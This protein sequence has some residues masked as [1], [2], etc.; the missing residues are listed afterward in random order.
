MKAFPR[1]AAF[2]AVAMA[3]AVAGC[4]GGGGGQKADVR[5][6]ILL[7]TTGQP[8]NPAATVSIAGAASVLTLTDGTFIVRDAS[9][10]ATE[11]NV[12]AA[13]MTPLRQKLPTLTPNTVNDLG[14]IFLTDATYDAD[15]DGTVVRADTLAPLANATIR[16]SGL[17]AVSAADGSFSIQGLPVG[18]GGTTTPVGLVRATRFEDKPIILDF[19][20]GK[21][22]NHLGE[23]PISPPVGAIPGGPTTIQGKVTLQGQTVHTGTSLTLIRVSDG[24]ELATVLT[25]SDGSFGFWVPVGQYRLRAEHTGYQTQTVDANVLRLDQPV[26]VNITLT[27]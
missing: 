4:G 13:G 12:T 10:A 9:A 16:I 27:P 18:L 3:I 20:L 19:P 6:R 26:T 8:P 24:A 2:G 14:D 5:G 11:I 7:V 21:G 17:T 25:P 22:L 1:I 23:I 15:V